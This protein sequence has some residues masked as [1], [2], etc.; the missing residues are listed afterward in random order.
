VVA[1]VVAVL[2]VTLAELAAVVLVRGGMEPKIL[3]WLE[4]KILVVVVAVVLMVVV[5]KE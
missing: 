5:L 2:M 3:V 4:L 1:E